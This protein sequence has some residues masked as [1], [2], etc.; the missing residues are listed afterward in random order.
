MHVPSEFIASAKEGMFWPLCI[1]LW[2]NSTNSERILKR[3]QEI[4]KVSLR[5]RGDFKNFAGLAAL[6]EVCG[7]LS[8]SG[9]LINQK[10]WDRIN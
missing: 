2:A 7:L 3:I 5:D 1:C 6:A 4:L 9:L 8:A 10:H